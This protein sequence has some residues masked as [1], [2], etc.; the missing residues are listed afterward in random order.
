MA[1]FSTNLTYDDDGNLSGEWLDGDC[2]CDGQV[3]ITDIGAFNLALSDPA[4]YET[5]YPGCT[6]V[7]AD[8]NNDGSVD[9]LDINPFVDLLLG[10]GSGGRRLV[11]DAENRLIGVRPAVEDEDLPDEALRSEFAYDYLNRRVM[12]RVYEWDEGCQLSLKP[13][14]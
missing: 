6:L 8:A 4:E 10:G 1:A 3:N 11:W 5:T 9:V 7:T 14:H 12:K 2:N 13:R